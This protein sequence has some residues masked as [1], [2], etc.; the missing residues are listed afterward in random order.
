MPTDNKREPVSEAASDTPDYG[1]LVLL[2]AVLI[3]GAA[4]MIYE[5]VAIRILQRYFGGRIDVWASEIAVC[6]GGLAVGYYLG[7][8]LADKHQSM[9]MLGM[10][11][12]FSGI[13]GAL[14][15]N[16]AE[17]A[18]EALLQVDVGLAWHPLIAAGVSSFLPF[19]TLG[20]VLPQAIRLYVPGVGSIG[21]AAGNIAAISTV[22]SIAGVLAT[23]MFLLTYFGVKETLYTTSAVLV[24]TG[25]V[26]A[27]VRSKHVAI[28]LVPLSAFLSAPVQAQIIFEEY[29]AYHH[30]LVEDRGDIRV[31]RFDNDEES[32]MSLSDPYA[33][34]FEYTDFFHVPMLLDPTIRRV[35][36]I[37]LGGATGPKS[38]LR[39]YPKVRMEVVEID[40]MV[41]RVTKQ[42]FA[43]PETGRIRI[44]INDGRTYI[45][46]STGKYG[47]IILDAYA[48]SPRGSY[49]PYHLATQEFFQLTRDRLRNG[50]CLVYNVITSPGSGSTLDDITATLRSVFQVIFAFRARTSQNTVLVA[51][52][53]DYDTLKEDGTRSGKGWPQDPWLAYPISP[54]ELQALAT[55]LPQHGIPLPPNLARRLGQTVRI[56]TR[57]RI[58]TDDY[59]PTD[60]APRRR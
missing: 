46:R 47:A 10:G 28:I 57:G 48:S 55:E 18:G 8:R 13:T 37:G 22:G 56:S 33:G 30:I 31:L 29:S 58:L 9:R 59:A 39:T 17:A 26:V 15:V 32:L 16:I 2:G 41:V 35:L 52:K 19:V 40:P 44:K 12:V 24:V 21:K 50:G 20:A 11:L 36:F 45:R 60:T 25:F 4:V 14:V 42:Y 7:G 43:L 23:G 53:I 49:I 51:M 38:F 27:G 6:M 34:G 3:S 5:F 54:R 1:R